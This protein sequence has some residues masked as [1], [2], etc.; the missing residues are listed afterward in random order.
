MPA[1]TQSARFP[2][3]GINLADGLKVQNFSFHGLGPSEMM[4]VYLGSFTSFW[5]RTS[6]KAPNGK[7]SAMAIR[8]AARME[9]R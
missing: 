1:F 2:L 3:T 5:S 7:R 6:E 8:A 4:E 9:V